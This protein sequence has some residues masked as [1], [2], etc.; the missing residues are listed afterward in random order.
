MF[1]KCER[2]YAHK[3][4]TIRLLKQDLSQGDTNTHADPQTGLLQ[5]PN[6]RIRTKGKVEMLRKREIAFPM[7]SKVKKNSK[8]TQIFLKVIGFDTIPTKT[9][10]L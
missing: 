8:A 6:P 7:K 3:V 10:N 5:G 9:L 2:S 1:Y 4:S